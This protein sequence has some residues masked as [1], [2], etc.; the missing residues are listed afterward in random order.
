LSLDCLIYYTNGLIWLCAYVSYR[1][2]RARGWKRLLPE[3]KWISVLL[4]NLVLYQDPF[5]IP[6]LLNRFFIFRDLSGSAYIISA[7]FM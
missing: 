2:L 7:S 1:K 5:F 4:I 6:L 3:Q